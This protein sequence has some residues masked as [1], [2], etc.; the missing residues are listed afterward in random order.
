[1]VNRTVLVGHVNEAGLTCHQQELWEAGDRTVDPDGRVLALL[2]E[3]TAS[4]VVRRQ[5]LHRV[6]AG[7]VTAGFFTLAYIP[8]TAES[9]T[10]QT[11]AGS[12]QVNKKIVGVEVVTPDFDVLNGNELH[13]NNAGLA[14]GLGNIIKVDN[15]LIVVYDAS[16]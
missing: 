13:F 10:V 4:G 2:S 12:I 8:F 1:M 3:V 14:T 15:L 6:T 16:L 7:E 9:V 5:E 11:V